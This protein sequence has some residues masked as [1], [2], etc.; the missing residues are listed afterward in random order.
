MCVRGRRQS[1][2]ENNSRQPSFPPP[3]APYTWY[4]SPH[5]P[6]AI[7]N[8]ILITDV[9]IK[10]IN[11]IQNHCNRLQFNKLCQCVFGFGCIEN[12]AQVFNGIT[13]D[14]DRMYTRKLVPKTWQTREV[15]QWKCAYVYV[16]VSV[17]VCMCKC[18]V[19][20]KYKLYPFLPPSR[21]QKCSTKPDNWIQWPA[22]E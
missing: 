1:F 18:V 17:C 14:T 19:V 15:L 6:H 8:Y 20:C 13:D 22:Y 10:F 12:E 5:I 7:F 3:P 2:Y 21:S 16:Y 9:V 11:V 4:I